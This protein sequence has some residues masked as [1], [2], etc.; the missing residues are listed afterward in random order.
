MSTLEAISAR[1]VQV[2]NLLKMAL[3]SGNPAQYKDLIMDA[4]RKYEDAVLA[5]ELRR[6]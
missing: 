1:H 2:Q 4:Q 3:Q 5:H 6:V